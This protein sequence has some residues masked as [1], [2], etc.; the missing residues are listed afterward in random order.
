MAYATLVG[1]EVM[2]VLEDSDVVDEGPKW[3]RFRQ[4]VKEAA[5]GISMVTTIALEVALNEFEKI[6]ARDAAVDIMVGNGCD[7]QCAG[8]DMHFECNYDNK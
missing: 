5:H 1:D 8:C 7:Q 4:L 3:K 6:G 2:V